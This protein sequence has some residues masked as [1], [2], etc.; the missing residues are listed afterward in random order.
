MERRSITEGGR[1]SRK[2]TISVIL[3]FLALLLLWPAELW[4][5]PVNAG[6]ARKTVRGWLNASPKPL[7]AA[8]GSQ[9][10]GVDTFTGDA[11]E[12]VYYVVYLAPSGF[13]VVPADDLVEPIIAFV[14]SGSYDPSDDNPLGALVS[15]DVPARVAAA[16]TLQSNAQALSSKSQK[17]LKKAGAAAQ[18]KWADIQAYADGVGTLGLSGISD[19]RVA[20]LTQSTWGQTTVGDYYGGITC[21]NYYTPSHYPCGCVATA[22]SQLIR[23]HEYPGSGPSGSYVWSNM[24]LEPNW[25]IADAERQA[26]GHLCYDA[27]ES[28]DTT[29]GSGGSSASLYDASREFR[30]T[31]SY[32]RSIYGYN[33]YNEI[34][35]ALTNM[36]LPNLDASHPVVLGIHSPGAHGVVCDGY[37]YNTATL[38]HHLNMG[39]SGHDNAW[40]NLPTI[41][42]AETGQSY[43]IVDTC[44]YNVFTSGSGEIISGRITDPEGQPISG[45]T[46]S[47]GG[48]AY[49]DTS[50][51][52][53]IYA[54]A[55]VPSGGGYTVSA[56]KGKWNFS[57]Q[58]VTTGTSAQ[59]S[60]TCGNRWGINFSGT[61]SAGLVEFGKEAYAAPESIS[62]RLI[63]SDLHGAGPQTVVLTI[64]GGDEET[65]TVTE[66]PGGTGVFKGSIATA[67]GATVIGDGTVQVLA[68]Q[69]VGG[70]Y[71]DADNG[72]G[73]PG[74]SY[75]SAIL[76]PQKTTIYST[77]FTGGLPAGWSTVDG[78]T[79]TDTWSATSEWADRTSPYWTGTFMI[80]DSDL[81]GY[82]IA[83]NEELISCGI[84]CS[85]YRNVALK[86]GHYFKWSVYNWDELCDVDVR[87]DGGSWQ[88]LARY[89]G[90]DVSGLVELD[91]SAYAD[92][93]ANVQVRWHYYNALWEYWWGID[94][95]QVIGVLAAEPIK[96][97]FEPDCDVDFY[98]FAVLASAWRSG[99]GDANWNPACDIS[100][101]KDGLINELDLDQLTENWLTGT[102]P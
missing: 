29:Y 39:W 48:G 98:D 7:G 2:L 31:F 20:P 77:N 74:T 80:A 76:A 10:A 18:G 35:S 17:A 22:M 28:V 67:N 4:A 15:G 95:V 63:D 50:N 13:V 45:V 33:N 70:V 32:S 19:V 75:G 88:R 92:G 11:G 71:Q 60:T 84:N 25:H 91:L 9:I 97:D 86:F 85:A 6:Q 72:T 68:S 79:S 5:K 21:Y 56:S 47:A 82:G 54:L 51:A 59:S 101:P 30:D 94:D 96:G 16:R 66:N 81:A 24:P 83:M 8:L 55:K 90:A 78:G 99:D 61:I 46:V 41:V 93:Q 27:A 23:Y 53:G 57:N 89:T 102:G 64:C 36:I 37:G 44:V 58:P 87:A 100:E 62:I 73:S 65:V 69:V 38:Y 52:Q 3:V 40:Y 42:C 49:T 34:G 12:P 43:S 1:S 14:A 26:I